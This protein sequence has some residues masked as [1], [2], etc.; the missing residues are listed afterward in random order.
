MVMG[1]PVA[2]LITNSV[3]TQEEEVT[4]WGKRMA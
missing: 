3:N 1:H 2:E 4:K